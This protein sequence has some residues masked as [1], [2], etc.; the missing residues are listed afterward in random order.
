[1]LFYSKYQHFVIAWSSISLTS[2]HD[3]KMSITMSWDYDFREHSIIMPS[4]VLV[5]YQDFRI[6]TLVNLTTHYFPFGF[7]SLCIYMVDAKT[8]RSSN[9][10]PT[11]VLWCN[12]WTYDVNIGPNYKKAQLCNIM[13]IK[14]V[15]II[16]ST[17]IDPRFFWNIT[18]IGIWHCQQFFV[19]S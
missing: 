2:I 1:M 14:Y 18:F 7:L 12:F 10:G 6:L 4:L 13:C 3:V 5:K 19:I 9:L 16:I 11:L 17:S 8:T 15:C